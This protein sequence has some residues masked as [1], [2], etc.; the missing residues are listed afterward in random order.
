MRQV[1]VAQIAL[2]DHGVKRVTVGFGTT[3]HGV[4]FRGRDHF[5]VTGTT[6]LQPADELNRDSTGEVGILAVS[7]HPAATPRKLGTA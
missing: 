2:V 7:L 3:V 4:V 5:Q 1:S 6:T